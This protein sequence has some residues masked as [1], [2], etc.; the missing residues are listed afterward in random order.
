MDPFYPLFNSVFLT[1]TLPQQ[2]LESSLAVHSFLAERSIYYKETWWQIALLPIR[3]FFEG[4]DGI[5]RLFDGRLNPFLLILPLLSF[6]LRPAD[7]KKTPALNFLTFFALLYFVLASFTSVLRIRYLTPIIPALV[8]LSIYGL[9]YLL[10]FIERHLKNDLIKKSV[11]CSLFLF[12]F[13]PNFLYI[14]S[15]FSLV[16]PLPFILG[17]IPKESYLA[18]HL[19]DYKTKQF[20]NS[21]LPGNSKLLCF[22]SGRRGYYLDRPHLF[23]EPFEGSPI[24]K[25]MKRGSL[26]STMA[27]LQK[28][29]ITHLLVREDLMVKTIRQLKDTSL[30]KKWS[31]LFRKKTKKMYTENGYSLFV[32]VP[33]E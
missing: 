24:E 16:N 1:H 17:E 26:K 33:D 31:Y 8:T 15:Q 29:N 7:N 32:L 4:K 9:Y 5:P 20:I 3:I 28:N 6:V 30:K 11:F 19:P 14:K 21:N 12:I 10:L 22:F 2:K 13:I 25:T 27:Y 18:E 23:A